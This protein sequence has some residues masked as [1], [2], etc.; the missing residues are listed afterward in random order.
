MLQDQLPELDNEFGL[1]FGL[2]TEKNDY[3]SPVSQ[4]TFSWGGAF[5]T[6]YWADPKEDLIGVIYTNIFGNPYGYIHEKFK[7]FAYQAIVD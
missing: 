2:E 3:G 1:G 6:Q 7:V 4:G 5:S